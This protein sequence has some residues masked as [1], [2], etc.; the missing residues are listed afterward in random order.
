MVMRNVAFHA[1]QTQVRSQLCCF[2]ALWSLIHVITGDA[3]DGVAQHGGRFK[4]QVPSDMVI[5]CR[6]A[7][8]GVRF[9][10]LDIVPFLHPLVSGSWSLIQRNPRE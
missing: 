7:R 8:A 3:Q 4:M 10:V 5:S 6:S 1:L 9:C 2:L